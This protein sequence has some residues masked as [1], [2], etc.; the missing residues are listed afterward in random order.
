MSLQPIWI[1]ED[2]PPQAFPDVEFALEHPNGLLAVGGDLG[3]ARLMCAYRRGVF[4]WFSRG[5]PILWWSPDPRAVLFPGDLHITRS[6][7][8]TLRQERYRITMNQAFERVIRHCAAPRTMQNDTWITNPM[9]DAYCRLHECGHAHSVEAWDADQL[10]GGLYGVSIGQVFFGESMFSR[11]PDSSK[12]ALA[13]L[14][15]VGYLLIDCQLP[16]DH[17]TRLG[18]VNLR[19]RE[20]TALLDRW[21]DADDPS[22]VAE[23]VWTQR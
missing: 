2:A 13:H 22:G 20:F 21:C 17:L 12:V 6:L 11:A 5:Q 8:K 15:R 19:R 18:S 1:T 3:P 9:I 14:C 4:P 7:R 16:N 23:M 10:V